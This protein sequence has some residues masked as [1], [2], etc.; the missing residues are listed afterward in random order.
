MM[1]DATALEAFREALNALRPGWVVT[2]GA[3]VGPDGA[4][5]R[6]AERDVSRIEGHVDVQ[7]V[8]DD[9]SPRRVE[10]WDCVVGY[11]ATAAD[12]AR[13]AANMWGQTTAGVLL[14]LKYSRRGEFADH[15]HAADA[16]GFSGWHSIAGAIVG[17]GKGESPSALQRW[18]LDNPVLPALARALDDSLNEPEGPFGLKILFGGDGIAEVRVNGEQHDAASSALASLPWPRLSPAGFVRSYVLVLHREPSEGR[19]CSH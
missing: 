12:R 14:E 3:I 19:V 7:F 4:A 9:A 6:L 13:F 10:L 15:Y 11:G 18:W 8:L 1:I 17:F 16:G 5:V 2:G